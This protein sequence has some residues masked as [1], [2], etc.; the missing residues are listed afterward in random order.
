MNLKSRKLTLVRQLFMTVRKKAIEK[1]FIAMLHIFVARW[2]HD[3]EK[4][5][6][7][8]INVLN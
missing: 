8:E 2:R 1:Y 5:H 6:Y 7:L 4:I 3:L